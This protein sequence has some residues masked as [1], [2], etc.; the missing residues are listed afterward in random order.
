MATGGECKV[1][2]GEVTEVATNWSGSVQLSLLVAN[3]LSTTSPAIH[4]FNRIYMY[5]LNCTMPIA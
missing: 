5:L 4:A 3:H 2:S 1:S